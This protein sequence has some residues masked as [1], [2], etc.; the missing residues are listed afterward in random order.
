MS[1]AIFL[2]ERSQL[3][4]EHSTAWSHC[5]AN[6]SEDHRCFFIRPVMKDVPQLHQMMINVSTMRGNKLK[7]LRSRHPFQPPVHPRKNSMPQT[8]RARRAV[9]PEH[10]S[11]MPDHILVICPLEW[12]CELDACTHLLCHRNNFWQILIRYPEAR[13]HFCQR[14]GH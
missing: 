6:V 14:N 11:S 1:F 2:I 7:F 3:T 5:L 8:P 9:S 10:S 12:L 4:D 13:V